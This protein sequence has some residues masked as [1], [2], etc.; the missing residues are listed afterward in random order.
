MNLDFLGDALDHWKGCL[1]GSLQR[2]HILHNFAVDPM[3]SDLECWQEEDF[4]L[5]A[6]LLSV[7]RSQLVE[8]GRPGLGNRA[9][10]FDDIVQKH[11]GDLFLDPDTGVATGRITKQHVKPSEIAR[12]LLKAPDRLLIVYQ[13]VRGQRVS[14]RV[15]AVC[16]KL[17]QELPGV[18]WCSYESGSVAMLFLA[19]EQQRTEAVAAHF[20]GLL[21][22]HAVR[23]IRVSANAT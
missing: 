23:R 13:H 14:E 3:A 18:R 21:G 11:T 12:L 8:H 4:S 22:R 2:S 16:A 7:D 1:F 10:Y 19:S 6:R 5:F 15:D 9:Q 17:C 20:R